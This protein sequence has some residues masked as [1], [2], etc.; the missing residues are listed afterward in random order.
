MEGRERE[1]EIKTEN[2]PYIVLVLPRDFRSSKNVT[3]F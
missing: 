3:S 1:R 2:L